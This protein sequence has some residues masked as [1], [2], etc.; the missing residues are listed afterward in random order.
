[1]TRGPIGP[2]LAFL[3]IHHFG[4]LRKLSCLPAQSAQSAFLE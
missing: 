4:N 3:L 1:M 2:R